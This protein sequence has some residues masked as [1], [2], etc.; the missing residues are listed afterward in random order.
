M[1]TWSFA[2]FL[3]RYFASWQKKF[4]FHCGQLLRVLIISA[5]G[6]WAESSQKV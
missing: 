4:I 2:A 3:I 1:T 5:T 6:T